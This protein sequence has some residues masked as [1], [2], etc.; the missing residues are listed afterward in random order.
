[1][2]ST[3]GHFRETLDLFIGGS[4]RR[5]NYLYGIILDS[6]LWSSTLLN[7]HKSHNSWRWVKTMSVHYCIHSSLTILTMGK[8][9]SSWNFWTSIW[10][11]KSLSGNQ[12]ISRKSKWK[13]S[14]LYLYI[15]IIRVNYSTVQI[16]T[17]VYPI[18]V[19]ISYNERFSS[20]NGLFYTKLEKMST[21]SVNSR[22]RVGQKQQS[23]DEFKRWIAYS[24]LNSWRF[25]LSHFHFTQVMIIFS[26]R[27]TSD[28]AQQMILSPSDKVWSLWQ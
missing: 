5:R 17:A 4:W 26:I 15:H 16:S 27:I 7:T 3:K 25:T 13:N 28:H 10:C 6:T 9:W 21:D 19:I 11:H 2:A 24:Y 23:K 12:W 22:T 18:V 1:M 14:T 8:K 20:M